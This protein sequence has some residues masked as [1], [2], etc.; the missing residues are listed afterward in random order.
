MFC[1]I[2]GNRSEGGS[3]FCSKCG[4]PLPTTSPAH[5]TPYAGRGKRILAFLLDCV[6]VVPLT[7]VFLRVV[8]RRAFLYWLAP[9]HVALPLNPRTLWEGFT[10]SQKIEALL[11]CLAGLSFVPWI[12][13]W[14]T[15]ASPA[16]ATLGKIALGIKVTDLQGRRMSVLRSAARSA[17][18]ALCLLTPI[19]FLAIANLIIML[20]S[21][22]K[23]ALHDRWT[24][25]VVTSRVTGSIPK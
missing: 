22:R 21:N 3:L 6:L 16:E 11:L 19:P 20:V 10:V 13:E 18:K 14:L 7:L 5:M 23:Q 9:L 2:C 25:C 1:A 24:G 4:A 8:F 12:Y 17:L 15:E